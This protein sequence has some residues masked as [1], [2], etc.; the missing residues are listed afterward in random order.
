M[1]MEFL[2]GVPGKLKKLLDRLT[3]TRA[4]YLD[5]LPRLDTN[6]ASRAPAST[7]L[8]SST[9]T[10]TRAA[11]LDANISS[12]LSA[13]VKTGGHIDTTVTIPANSTSPNYV[14]VTIPSVN[15]GKT[16]L[17]LRCAGSYPSEIDDEEKARARYLVSLIN[18]TTVRVFAVVPETAT[19]NRSFYV[20]WTYTEFY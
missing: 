5:N 6:I 16:V 3:S 17:T 11:R 4:G 13:V 1:S 15:A 8:S 19:Y 7:A 10:A 2:M 9:W 12:R 14:D 20:Y 18:S